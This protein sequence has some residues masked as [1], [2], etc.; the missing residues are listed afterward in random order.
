MNIIIGAVVAW[1]TFLI[2]FV[3]GAVWCWIGNRKPPGPPE[4]LS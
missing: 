3:L 4:R 1:M 2:G